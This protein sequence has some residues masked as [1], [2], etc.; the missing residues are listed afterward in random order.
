[1]SCTRSTS[2]EFEDLCLNPTYLVSE[3]GLPFWRVLVF[4][5]LAVNAH[6]PV[7]VFLQR[8]VRFEQMVDFGLDVNCSASTD[9]P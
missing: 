4:A 6:E 3:P 2:E 8:L 5:L 9:V 7:K 1:M